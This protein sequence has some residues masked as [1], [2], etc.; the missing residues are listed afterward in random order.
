MVSRREMES[1]F[2][3]VALLAVATYLML[4]MGQWIFVAIPTTVDPSLLPR[5]VSC[6]I[7]ACA[8]FLVCS[9]IISFIR[10]K[11]VSA[12]E[13]QDTSE[14]LYYVLLYIVVLLLYVVS[15]YYIGFLI[16]TPIVML[17]VS[18]MLGIRRWFVGLVCYVIFT[19]LL[20]YACVHLMQ[21]I[22][23][24]GVLFSSMG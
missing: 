24:S 15:V 1:L 17:V 12:A 5:I 4:N 19:M 3:N 2:I 7:T 11:S 23:P 22:L 14:N 18:F 21:V 8:T 20:Y 16:S 6:I 10:K 13:E 9:S